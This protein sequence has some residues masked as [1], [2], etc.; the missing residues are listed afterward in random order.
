MTLR[1]RHLR[2]SDD[3]S[4]SARAG[5]VLART[6]LLVALAC[7]VVA[8]LAGPSYRHEFI[9]LGTAFTALRWAV[10][11][12]LGCAAAAGVA[13]VLLL[14][15]RRRRGGRGAAVGAVLVSVAVATPPLLLVREAR[16]LPPIHDISTSPTDPP[17]FV[18]IEPLR[19]LAS[20]GIDYPVDSARLQPAAY[21]DIQTFEIATPP[22]PTF[23][24]A[25]RAAQAMR[26]QIVSVAPRD[27]RIEA[28][29]H[30]FMF[31][32]KDDIVIRVRP[33]AEGSRLDVRS[34]SRVGRGDMGVN[35][36]RIRA[37]LREFASAAAS[38]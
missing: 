26:W 31:G 20:N 9:P 30:S 3:E 1:R 38:G 13:L 5:R 19:R 23:E 16:A 28:T 18:A 35:A 8:L 7:A 21:P 12:A 11:A 32:F 2:S 24:R 6:A 25:L 14:S 34:A 37:Y 22:T 27:G 4:A 36:K 15:T 10:L 17:R 33:S 29:A